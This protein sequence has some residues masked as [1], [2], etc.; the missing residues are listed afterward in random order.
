M[1]I[2]IDG[3]Y[4]VPI[5]GPSPNLVMLRAVLLKTAGVSR[6]AWAGTKATLR[7]VRQLP[8][9]VAVTVSSILATQTGYTALT[10]S[11]R[12]ATRLAW[13][14]FRL[15]ARGLGKASR[16]IADL[17]TLAVGY[18]SASGADW[19]LRVSDRIAERVVGLAAK[20]DAAV[21]GTGEL[22][23][24]LAHTALVRSAVTVAASASSAVFVVHTVTQGLLAV[25]ILQAVPA[26]MTAVVWATDPWRTL[27]LVGLTA[28]A[29]MGIALARLVSSTKHTDDGQPEPPSPA[30]SASVIRPVAEPNTAQVLDFE[31][32]AASLTIEI[33]NDGSVIV[34]G[35]PMAVPIEDGELIAHIATE[36]ALKHWRRTRTSRPTPSRDDRR[37]F[38]KAAKE[39][40]RRYGKD[41]AA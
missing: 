5:S 11:V 15:L 4:S 10:G 25:K 8:R 33:T 37:L 34:H 21:T 3:T 41:Q 14:G 26:L 39:A 35:I 29:A 7:L 19:T 18:V 32:I 20:V 9:S 28:I 16:S 12:A 1:D 13:N 2:P 27:A 24:G 40:V 36:A 23:W 30:A 38:T 31:K 6:Q 17:V 22:L